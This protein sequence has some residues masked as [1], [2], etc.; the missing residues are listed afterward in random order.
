MRRRFAATTILVVAVLSTLVATAGAAVPRDATAPPDPTAAIDALALPD[1]D[2]VVK[3]ECEGSVDD[4]GD[5]HV[6]CRWRLGDT[7]VR[8]QHEI[9]KW[10]LWSIQLKP[11]QGHRNLVAELRPEQTAY[12]D[13]EVE[14]PAAYLYAVL[15]L[16]ARGEIVA[17]SRPD[18][19]VVA[20]RPEREVLR[21]ACRARIVDVAPSLSTDRVAI[22]A[23]GRPV[24]GC[25]WSP[26]RHPRAVGYHLYRSAD[27]GAR[28][29][30]ART[31][32]DR[33]SAVDDSVGFG[34]RYAYVVAAVDADG[35]ILSRSRVARVGI[36]P[37]TRPVE[38]KPSEIEPVDTRPVEGDRAEH[39]PDDR[40]DAVR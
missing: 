12:R 24:V 31:G 15:G 23:P 35:T 36:P 30:V 34:H 11:T 19:A 27:G 20:A 3:L 38:E 16:D 4:S 9:V 25:E 13:D 39:R 37:L 6:G 5:G 26:T 32:L 18:L 28:E 29:V 33:T 1:V 8:P 21:L 10:Q 40:V 2:T 17:R 14:A 7:L 22:D